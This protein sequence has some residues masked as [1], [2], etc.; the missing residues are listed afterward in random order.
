VLPLAVNGASGQS[1]FLVP[2][3]LV[4][5][6]LLHRF[7]AA[8]RLKHHLAHRADAA[9]VKAVAEDTVDADVADHQHAEIPL[10][11]RFGTYQSCQ[12]VY[13]PAVRS[14]NGHCF[15]S[16]ENSHLQY[17]DGA[18]VGECPAIFFAGAAFAPNQKKTRLAELLRGAS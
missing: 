12:H 10:G 8:R 11:F 17:T 1:P 6:R 15:T 7:E 3:T 5:V 13:I 4:E 14:D 2:G 16:S 18:P 9:K